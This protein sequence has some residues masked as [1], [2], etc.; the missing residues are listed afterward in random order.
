MAEGQ[1]DQNSYWF[2]L[3]A[4]AGNTLC[5]QAKGGLISKADAAS[6]VDGIRKSAETD[7]DLIEFKQDFYNALGL[8]KKNPDCRGV[9]K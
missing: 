7:P 6:Y 2:G 3:T 1:Y 5:Q 9:I 4:R 8:L